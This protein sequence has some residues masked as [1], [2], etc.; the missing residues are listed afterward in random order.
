MELGGFGSFSRRQRNAFQLIPVRS[1]HS[2][3]C[4]MRDFSKIS[5][6]LLAWEQAVKSGAERDVTVTEALDFSQ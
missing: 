4:E 3:N 6:A 2:D 1:L 5:K